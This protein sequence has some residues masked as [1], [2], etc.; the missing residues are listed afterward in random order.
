MEKEIW[1][2][3]EGYED[4][5]MIS[6]Y[7]RVRSVDRMKTLSNGVKRLQ[8]GR[9]L[10]PAKDKDGY[11]LC[12]LSKNGIH[13]MCK[14]HRLVAQAFIPNPYNLPQINHKDEN[15][16]NNCVDNLEWCD[17][18][19]NANYGTR[20]KRSAEKKL[21][22]VLKIDKETNE[23][24]AEYPSLIETGKQTGFSVWNIS[25]CCLGIRKSTGGFKWKYK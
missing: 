5:Y 24:I 10:K 14:V 11:L 19:Y 1:K 9:I 8:K 7:G 6:S 22:P 17:G 21:K 25:A 4:D 12:I 20:N 15:K 3:I 23:V 2:D 13:T 16:A 18:K